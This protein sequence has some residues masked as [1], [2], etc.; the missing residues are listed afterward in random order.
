MPSDL[1]LSHA[2]ETVRRLDRDRFVTALFAAPDARERLM[3]LYAFNAE[4]AR[5]RES[6]HDPMA[7]M[8]RLQW[9][10]EA[11]AGEREAETGGHPVAGPLLAACRALK[12]SG[13]A[14]ERLLDARERDL[15]G[16][17]FATLDD[18]EAY[19][20]ATSASLTRL[21]L[22]LLDAR[23]DASRAAGEAVGTAFAL[24]GLLRAAAVRPV[25]PDLDRDR[26]RRVAERAGVLLTGARQH[27]VDRRGLAALLPA[28]IAS[29]HLR[30]LEKAGWDVR[31]PA[32]IIPKRMP[33]RLAFNA[34]RGRF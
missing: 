9:W 5:V 3:L 34:V 28:T 16:E 8:I 13:A 17:P 33:L 22:D 27:R 18:L 25:L 10:R 6:V 24:V 29:G 21:A 4:V 31:D 20:A 19:A 32:V 14:F 12:V 7:G 11:L 23:D 2:A 30:T 1:P 15:S 26:V